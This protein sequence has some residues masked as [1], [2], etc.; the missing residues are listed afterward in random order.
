MSHFTILGITHTNGFQ[1]MSLNFISLDCF[2]QTVL[3]KYRAGSSELGEGGE[4]SVV[5]DLSQRR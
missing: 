1:V 4:P 2:I 5:L 3:A